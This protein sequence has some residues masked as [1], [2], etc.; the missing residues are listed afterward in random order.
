MADQGADRSEAGSRT[1]N[2]GNVAT[3]LASSLAAAGFEGAREIG[4]GGFGVVYRCTEVSL[5]RTV[6][7][8]VLA[9]DLDEANRERFLREGY[10]MGRLSG[11]P[12]IVNILQVGV[13]DAGRPYIVMPYHAADSLALRLRREGPLPWPEVLKIG[14][15][16][17]GALETAHRADTLHR[18]IKP[19]NV[20]VNDYGEPQLTDF[21]IAH[22]AGGYETATGFFTGTIAYTA[23]EVLG[24]A[25]P[26]VAADIY[27]LGA[28]LY[29]LIAGSAAYERHSGEELVAQYLRISSAPVPDLRGD[30]I[31]LTVCEVIERAM[32]KN[33]A[34]R[35]QSV[36]ELG[37]ELQT[38]QRSS[39]LKPD[40]MALTTETIATEPT[41]T[42]K[43]FAPPPDSG[44]AAARTSSAA[45]TTP[46]P[47]T[48]PPVAA[49]KPMSEAAPPTIMGQAAPTPPT[50]P[51]LGT[52]PA[53]SPLTPPPAA[54]SGVAPIVPADPAAPKEPR[55]P[56]PV[57]WA[58]IGAIAVVL[59]LVIAG[60][61]YFALHKKSSGDSGS[62]TVAQSGWHSITNARIARAD[63]ATT[64]AD[65]TIWIFGGK[66]ASGVLGA[67]EGYDPPIDNWK[68]GDELPA[69]V[70]NASAVTWRGNPIVIG[71]FSSGQAPTD[72]V[73]RVVNS[74]WVELPPLLQPRAAAGAAVVGDRI[75]V[76]GGVGPDGK[77]TASTEIFD[78]TQWTRSTDIPTPRDHLGVVADGTAVYALGGRSGGTDMATVERFDPAAQTW[79]ALPNMTAPRSD[80]GATFTDGRI[81]VA[82]GE[83][84]GKILNT[85]A[86]FDVVGAVW[87]DLPSMDTARRGLALSSVGSDV[88]AF[89]GATSASDNDV[90]AT[91]ETVQLAPRTL[92]PAAQWRALP[93]APTARLQAAGAVA[94]GRV[95]IMG[96]L[97][98]GA[99]LQDVESF[100]PASGRWEPGPPMPVGLNHATAA[101]FRGEVIVLGGAEGNIAQASDKVFAL[102]GGTWVPLPNLKHARAGAAAVAVGDKLIIVGGQ[103]NKKL[104][105][106]TEVFNGSAW[107]DA[108]AP[109]TPREH[110]AAVTDG[111]YV[112]TVG[113]RFLSSDK[114]SAAFERFD[115]ASG[116]WQRLPDMPTPRGSFGAAVR[117]RANRG[118]RW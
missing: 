7:I 22:I 73:W 100:D 48:L 69:A 93:D 97:R 8:K 58:A 10:A 91:A 80:F 13:T 99:T 6:A 67:H 74:H 42:H 14:V 19:A 86:A 101:T 17:C 36:A 41:S 71:G 103:N 62:T 9:S 60:F 37:R 55:K 115:P 12:N 29:A 2:T 88:Y 26:A 117:R 107:K 57:K 45:Q 53:A 27:S 83:Q 75:I 44:S 28:T 35:P 24:G 66:G 49:I 109:P 51:P 16:L 90:M 30:G 114:N 47:S 4:R 95:W 1:P 77:P 33:P 38:A 110:L 104:V 3:Q 94:G 89:G 108:A 102:R 84:S 112:Y 21:G 106:E 81:V 20:L 61:T 11:H 63:A 31:P 76:T 64:Q 46:P 113:G 79:S 5:G 54:A 56:F 105:P 39:G 18:D 50:Q 111:K 68:G 85:V 43:V 59:L 96:G 40:S 23:P 98:N 52:T 15:K 92:Q 82:G 70:T 25:K 72:K 34:D 32:A 65:G 78:G 118:R 116:D 87:S